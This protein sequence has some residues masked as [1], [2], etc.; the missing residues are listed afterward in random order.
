MYHPCV[1]VY[2]PAGVPP[3]RSLYPIAPN[4]RMSAERTMTPLKT[5]TTKTYWGKTEPTASLPLMLLLDIGVREADAHLHI[6]FAHYYI[7]QQLFLI[8]L[9]Y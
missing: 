8:C 7:K 9:I 2:V 5:P 1:L 4:P 3:S 6:V